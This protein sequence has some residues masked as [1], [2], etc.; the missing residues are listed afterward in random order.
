LFPCALSDCAGLSPGYFPDFGHPAKL[1]KNSVKVR[2][3]RDWE[4]LDEDQLRELEARVG[5]AQL[6]AADQ[7]QNG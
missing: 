7:Q 2:T 5:I 6:L 4:V 3:S 1:V